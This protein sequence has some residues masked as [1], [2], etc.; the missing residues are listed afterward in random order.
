MNSIV[1]K[2]ADNVPTIGK[3]FHI[4]VYDLF[5]KGEY[6]HNILNM[7][8]ITITIISILESLENE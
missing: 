2:I 7:H 3:I 6:R 8:L 4:E 5:N 1:K